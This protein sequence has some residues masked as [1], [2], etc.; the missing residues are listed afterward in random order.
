MRNFRP[1]IIHNSYKNI[2]RNNQVGVGGLRPEV[3]VLDERHRPE[4]EEDA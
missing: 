1:K 2:T 3:D 4:M